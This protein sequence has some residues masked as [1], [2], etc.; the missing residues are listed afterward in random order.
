MV[1]KADIT[2][3]IEGLEGRLNEVRVERLRHDEIT[4][5]AA[6]EYWRGQENAI[7]E[8]NRFNCI[9]SEKIAYRKTL[10]ALKKSINRELGRDRY[11][12]R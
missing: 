4:D 8:M 10:R 5:R 7:R 9:T 2:D 11:V 3:L 1:D 12:V 6:N